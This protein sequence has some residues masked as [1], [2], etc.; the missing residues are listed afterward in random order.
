MYK[1]RFILTI[2]K[3]LMKKILQIHT[4]G[5]KKN[6]VNFISSLFNLVSHILGLR[7]ISYIK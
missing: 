4:Y 5:E 6:E 7:G 1:R 2:N 3:T